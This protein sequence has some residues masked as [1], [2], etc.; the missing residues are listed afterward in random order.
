MVRIEL[1]EGRTS[2]QKTACAR[3]V[4]KAIQQNLGAKPESTQ[5]VFID[6]APADWLIGSK[7]FPADAK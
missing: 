7:L 1:Y 6:V 2:E 5:V 3:D 4:I